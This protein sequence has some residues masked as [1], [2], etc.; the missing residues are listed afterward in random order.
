MSL[1]AHISI[2]RN[3]KKIRDQINHTVLW[4]TCPNFENRTRPEKDSATRLPTQVSFCEICKLFQNN[5]FEG[6]L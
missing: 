2:I 4:Q 1:F 3:F 6:H 5:Y